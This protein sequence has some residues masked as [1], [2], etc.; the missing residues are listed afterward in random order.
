MDRD[1]A[2]GTAFAFPG[3]GPTFYRDVAT[4][5]LVD[6]R[7]RA[8]SAEAGDV[9]GYDLVDRYR[10][11]G[12]GYSEYGQ[13][14]FLVN[15]LALAGWAEQRRQVT[16][17]LLTGASFGG[18]AAAV[19]SGAL[20]FADAVRMTVGMHHCE[21]DYF[22]REYVDVVTHSF[23]RTPV[24]RLD[25]ILAEL[26]DWHDISCHIDEDFFMVSLRRDRLDWF[27]AK[28]RAAG[29]LPLYTMTPPM[30]SSAFG[31]L[32]ERVDREVLAGLTFRDPQHPVVAD[33][34]GSIVD[35]AEGVRRML[36]DGYTRAVRWPAVVGALAARGVKTLYMCGSDSLF[37]R[38]P[39]TRR[40]FE[41][42]AVNPRL[43]TRPVRRPARSAA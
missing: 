34:D 13:V 15:C 1:S 17:D 23:A 43:A 38:V 35:T 20:D 7:A 42:V 29:G 36:L 12:T 37:G 8:L 28:L 32:R 30:H 39:V 31:A 40:A 24:A 18:K 10:D 11:D 21:T 22:A 19:H 3:M 6:P 26:D 5:M 14:A 25:E 9:L 4:F 41:V 33:Q 27:Q 2:A 16:P